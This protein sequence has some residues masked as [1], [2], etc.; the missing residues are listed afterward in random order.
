MSPILV[1][2]GTRKPAGI[3]MIA[4]L[5]DRVGALLHRGV[6][7]AF[8]DVLGPTPGE[9]LASISDS[10]DA[11]VVLPAFLSRGYHVRRD[12]PAH[13]T[14]SGHPNVTVTPALGP[15][16]HIVRVVAARL[17]ESGW[18][19]G[20]SVL[21]AAAGTSDPLA[22]A[23]LQ[24]VVKLLSALIGTQVGL[25]FAATGKPSVADAVAA[26]RR[27]SAHRV[28]VVSYL[29]ADGL[30]QQRL[31]NSGAD[32]VSEP[33]GSHPETAQLIASRFI[34]ALRSEPAASP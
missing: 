2:H 26:L 23:D 34:R 21:L 20:D 13:I 8:V 31:R 22:Q 3:A 33:L 19:S 1:A 15:G 17:T 5:A 25:A 6:R 18:R 24:L 9:I 29:L 32:V 11:A 28:V 12:L 7:V 4:D 10:G 30:F 27:Q 16:P 14:T